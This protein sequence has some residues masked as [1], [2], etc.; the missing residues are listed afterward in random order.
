M[1]ARTCTMFGG[2]SA[3]PGR[4]VVSANN[5]DREAKG[6]GKPEHRQESPGRLCN[7]SQ[8]DA[9]RRVFVRDMLH[10]LEVLKCNFDSGVG[11]R[12][13]LLH[14]FARTLQEYREI[15]ART[16]LS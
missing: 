1:T 11:M 13:C 10:Y 3:V 16:T 15:A 9:K 4:L 7:T 5:L 12:V 6:R 14:D 8:R 2:P